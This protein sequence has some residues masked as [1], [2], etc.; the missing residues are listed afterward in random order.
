MPTAILAR[1]TTQT[2]SRGTRQSGKARWQVLLLPRSR[3]TE[4]ALSARG[5][6][7][8][9]GVSMLPRKTV[10][11]IAAAF[12]PDE[13]DDNNYVSASPA[14]QAAMLRYRDFLKRFWRHFDRKGRFDAVITG[15]YGYCAERELAA[16]LEQLGVPFVAL[17]KE[18]SWSAGMQAFW[19]RIYRERRGPFLGRRIFVYSPLER[20][21]QIR[22]GVA[23]PSRIEVVG[24]PRLD[25]VHQ[26]RRNNIGQVPKPAVLFVSFHP[27][28]SMPVLRPNAGSTKGNRQYV[29]VDERP[30]G[31]NLGG[32]C[33][34]THRAM[35]ELARANPDITVLV[36]SKG[37][38]RDREILNDLLGVTRE[39]ELP[40]NLHVIMGGSPL[41]LLFQ[42]SVVCGLHSTL[43]VEALAAGRPV[44]V[45]WFDEV[46]DPAISRYVFDLGGAVSRAGSHDELKEKVREL[47]L[48]RT[49]VP[50]KLPPETLHVLREWVGNDDGQAGQRA[51]AAILRVLESQ[52]R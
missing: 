21:L 48:A 24:M 5:S 26:W 40:R 11:S 35:V 4:D 15:N 36:K 1:L 23:D 32:L 42:A 41:P 34:S 18:N 30:Q 29:L 13:V 45:P 44:V 10:K 39:D 8:A 50:A 2:V 31:S 19:E 46:L 37:R 12:F 6:I 16:A 33:R 22:A 28:V 14:A 47:A 51:A 9:V 52:R 7:D 3:F 27:D 25:E 43:L 17:H 49:P 20:D 38:D